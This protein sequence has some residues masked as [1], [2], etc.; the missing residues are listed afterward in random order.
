MVR[1]LLMA[2]KMSVVFWGPFVIRKTKLTT[3]IHMGRRTDME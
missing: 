3:A 2:A 1:P